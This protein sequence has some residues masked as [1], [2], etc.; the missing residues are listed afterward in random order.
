MGNCLASI[1][2]GDKDRVN[3]NRPEQKKRPDMIE[4]KNSSDQEYVKDPNAAAEPEISK[5]EP[6]IDP[7]LVYV[8][9]S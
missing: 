7:R 6:Q 3:K 5:P 8:P 1:G 2:A 4:S 9:L